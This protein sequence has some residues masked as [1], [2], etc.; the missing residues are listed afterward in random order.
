MEKDEDER[1]TFSSQF[2]SKLTDAFFVEDKGGI[3]RCNKE[4]PIA[5]KVNCSFSPVTAAAESG[6]LFQ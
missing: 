6:H 2:L 3:M 1:K 4:N 5:L